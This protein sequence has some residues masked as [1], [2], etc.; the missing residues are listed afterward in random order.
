VAFSWKS[1]TW[2]EILFRVDLEARRCDVAPHTTGVTAGALGKAHQYWRLLCSGRAL[3]DHGSWRCGDCTR[4]RRSS[5]SSRPLIDTI[6]SASVDIYESQAQQNG[7][8]GLEQKA[9]PAWGGR[10]RTDVR[11][12]GRA[13]WQ[14]SSRSRTSS[15]LGVIQTIVFI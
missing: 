12:H 6:T 15:M 13:I 2:C 10:A 3:S 7:S 1:D 8:Q 11:L 5:H 4:R 14:S 9:R